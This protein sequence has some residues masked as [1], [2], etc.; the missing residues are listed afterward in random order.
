ML[1]GPLSIE[2]VIRSCGLIFWRDVV[3][4]DRAAP[5]KPNAWAVR[6][7]TIVQIS[8]NMCKTISAAKRHPRKRNTQLYENCYT[9]R[10]A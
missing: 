6:N 1:I 4:G 10:A 5:L 9:T 7:E 3:G 8:P 2:Y